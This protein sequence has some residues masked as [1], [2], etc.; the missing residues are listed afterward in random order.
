M[1]LRVLILVIESILNEL[2]GIKSV[3]IIM[4][5]KNVN[6][7][8]NTFIFKVDKPVEAKISKNMKLD[9]NFGS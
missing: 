3:V 6:M 2:F 1:F 7:L 9:A 4:Y 5:Y 8:N